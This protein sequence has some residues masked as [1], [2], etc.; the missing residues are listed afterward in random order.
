MDTGLLLTNGITSTSSILTT[1]AGEPTYA[2]TYA[3]FMAEV[4]VE[5]ATGK[6]TVDKMT[7]VDWVGKVGN[8]QSVNGQ[9]FGG[10]SHAIG[11]ALQENYEDVRKDTNML[12][13]GVPYIKDI[14]DDMVAIHM[15]GY[16]ERGPFGSSGASEA[17]Q[18][19]DHVAVIN[20][21][22]NACGVRIYDLPAS[23][24]KVKAGIDAIARGEEPD[25]AWTSTS[26]V[27]NSMRSLRNLK[28]NPLS[29]D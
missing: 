24:E 13:A 29:W 7:C 9:A 11:F 5:T 12:R 28:A 21:I 27:Q 1:E 8:I 19:S 15:D 18:S 23:P 4:S 25:K 6:T 2:Y 16:D 17:F 22:N 10:M 20:A 14:P 3:L 26:S